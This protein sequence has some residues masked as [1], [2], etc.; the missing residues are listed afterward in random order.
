MQPGN[1]AS[2]VEVIAVPVPGG[3]LAVEHVI[4]R[5]EPVLAIHGISSQRKLWNWLRAQRP[6]L[7]LI[8]PDLRG[9]GDSVGVTGRSSVARHAA[10]L[11]AVLDH[12]G[13][14]AVPV[15]G[16]SMGGFV[17]VELATAYPD[18]VKSLV[19]VDG[20][21]P[22][23]TPPGLTPE[24]VPAIFRDRL[25]RLGR[26]WPTVEDY[27]QFFVA[28]TAP[29]LDPAD[30]LL[31]NYLAHDLDR[32][33]VRLSADALG[34]DATDIFFGPSKWQQIRQPVRLL[35]AEWSTGRDTA[36]AYPPGAIEHFHH[37]LKTLDRVETVP[38]VDH[39][40]SI[41]SPV[42]AQAT[43]GLIREAL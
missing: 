41:M 24:A 20:G 33:R 6:D 16:M 34:E 18:R 4:S 22:M 30:P 28:N 8:A 19:L 35:T 3:D 5:T 26:D 12:L 43:A 37:E 13:L 17:A 7:S 32:H 11:I 10:D 27:A 31:L 29:L 23:A 36:P 25:A 39:A 14:D 21:F 9:R 1:E 40:A 2:T 42:G 38:G 15:C